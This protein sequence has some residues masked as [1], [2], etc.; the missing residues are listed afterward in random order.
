VV[1]TERDFFATDVDT[2]KP[3]RAK[4]KEVDF[5]ATTETYLAEEYALK[6][7]ISR[8]ER[9]N[10]D[11][12]LRLE[13]TKL[14]L[15]QDQMA[16]AK[17]V[18]VATL[19]NTID[20]GGELDNSMDA[21]PS[22]NWN[23]DAGTIEADILAAKEAVYDSLGQGANTI[24]IPQKV[25]NAIIMQQDIREL[26]KYTVN[27]TQLISQDANSGGLPSQLFGLRVLVPT[28]R[29][30]SNAEGVTDSIGD[31]WGDDVR[32][33]YVA[34]GGGAYGSPTVAQAFQTRPTEVRRYAI[35]DPE[36][37]FIVSSEIRDE[38]VIAPKGGYVIKDLL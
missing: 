17:E 2:L 20:A 14:N 32:I 12:Q 38:K 34:P 13:Q 1:Y 19:L 3:D 4:T 5:Q 7:S 29:K 27:G 11:T 22:N 25:A 31:V 6:V 9:E 35:D 15:L 16:L 30:F 37:D 28:A 26:L 23:V 33:L 10:V 36:V 21:T 24:I 18:R 8:R